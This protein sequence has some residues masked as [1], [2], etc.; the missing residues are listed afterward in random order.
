MGR[1]QFCHVQPELLHELVD[2]CVARHRLVSGSAGE[3][4]LDI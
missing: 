1:N 2:R 4:A 3:D